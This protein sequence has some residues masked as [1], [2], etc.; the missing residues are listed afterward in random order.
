MFFITHL[1]KDYPWALGKY[2][3]RLGKYAV[4]VQEL[5]L[6]SET[7]KIY[8]SSFNKIVVTC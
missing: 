1:E 7:L 2:V 6:S 8:S 4:Q 3:K 5:E